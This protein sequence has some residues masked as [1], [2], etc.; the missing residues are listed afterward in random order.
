MSTFSN[1]TWIANYPDYTPENIT[2]N[3]ATILDLY[4]KTI[5]QFPYREAVSCH[6]VN[7]TFIELDKLATKMASFLQNNLGINKGDRVAI[8]LPNCLQFTVSLFACVKIGAVFVN[9]NPLYTADE[10]EA[11]FNNCN[12]KAAIVMDMF[13]HH[14]QK[15]RVNID[16]L[17][18]VIVTNIAD[19]YPFPKKQIIGFVS[20]YL[21]ENKPKYT[22]SNFIA[23]SKVIKADIS[24]YKK[25]VLTKQDILCLQYSSG[26]TGRPKGAI[27]THDNLASNI[28][29]VWAWI[30]HDM[31]MSDQVIIT[32]LPLYHIFSLSANLLCFFFAGAKNVLIPNARDIKNLIKTMSKNEFTIF[33]G[34]NT[35]YMAM[36][37]HPNFEKINKTRYLYSLSGG[38]PISR[39]IYLEWLDRTGVELKE[40]YGMTEMSPA[41]ALNKFNESEDDYF[42]TCGYPI[43]STELS[44][45]DIHTHQEITECFKEGEI[46]LKGPQ[47][48]QGFWNDKE[49]NELHFTADG[50]LK[51][52][53]I[54]YIDKK[55]RLTISDR[56]KNMIIVSGFN[57]YPREIELC[58]LKL[59]YVREVAVTGIKSKTSGE[60]PIA[61][62]SLE[63]GSNATEEDIIKHCKDKLASYKVPR[64][65]IFVETLPKNNTSKID[66]KKL[67]NQFL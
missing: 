55:G 35:L 28:Q 29:Q 52:G 5:I 51:T 30:K 18:N 10:I 25:P 54:G 58:I 2:E 38:M 27:L 56:I 57:V 26:T 17:E 11:I 37:E 32:A 15:A 60:R 65:C 43:P 48:C 39:K 46:W 12:V 61:F 9:T 34:L 20:K 13:A 4:E 23:F 59:D 67:K 16:S 33:N 36:L 44:I 3:H 41:I 19:L 64:S 66:I 1:K 40:G 8:V 24:L 45:R 42:G 22:K 14:I 7:L 49:N 50:W 31:D 21:I 53:D 63:K 47:R 62:I 6:D